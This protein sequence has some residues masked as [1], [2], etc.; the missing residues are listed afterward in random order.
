MII[1]EGVI[2][3]I[4]VMAVFGL[5]VFLVIRLGVIRQRQEGKCH[6][7]QDLVELENTPKP[8]TGRQHCCSDDP[9]RYGPLQRQ[10][11]RYLTT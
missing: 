8:E 1:S 6:K 5:I 10:R 9:C 3:G 4:A 11:W 2:W 7:Q